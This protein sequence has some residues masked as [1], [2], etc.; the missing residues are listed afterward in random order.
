MIGL[1]EYCVSSVLGADIGPIYGVHGLSLVETQSDKI[2]AITLS[3]WTAQRL[4]CESQLRGSL[5]NTRLNIECSPFLGGARSHPGTVPGF[6]THVALNG[7]YIMIMLSDTVF[8]RELETRIQRLIQHLSFS[9]PSR[10]HPSIHP[11]IPPPS[12]P[13]WRASHHHPLVALL[14]V[15]RNAARC[16]WSCKNH[17]LLR[18]LRFLTIIRGYRPAPSLAPV[19]SSRLL[20]NGQ[21]STPPAYT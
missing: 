6:P 11:S 5:G 16:V 20:I 21:T 8:S 9:P 4:S 14:L 18:P 7:H 2:W 10:H 1:G 13:S 12:S 3:E 15:R 17:P 19:S